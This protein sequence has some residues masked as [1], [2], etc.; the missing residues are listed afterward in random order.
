MGASI[1]RQRVLP[2]LSVV[3]VR[4]AS[5]IGA[6]SLQ[7]PLLAGRSMQMRSGLLTLRLPTLSPAR[8]AMQ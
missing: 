2:L 3:Q 1:L 7:K 8:T 6:V 5:H 4:P